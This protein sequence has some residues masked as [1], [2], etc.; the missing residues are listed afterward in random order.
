MNKIK[1]NIISY[2]NLISLLNEEKFFISKEKNNEEMKYFQFFIYIIK[3]KENL[4]SENYSLKE[5]DKN[6]ILE[7]INDLKQKPQENN[8]FISTLI[9]FLEKK[10]ITLENLL[11]KN[12]YININEFMN[13]LR[14]NEFKVENGNFDLFNALQKYQKDENSGNIDIN[15]L[16]NDLE[17][18]R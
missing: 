9:N 13:I 3:E 16:K 14:E 5:F 1:N 6:N 11:G 8:D 17:K 10:N 15:Y 7:L 2:E 18:Y 12:D 4:L